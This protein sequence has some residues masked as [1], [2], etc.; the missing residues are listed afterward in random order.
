M[1]FKVWKLSLTG[2]VGCLRDNFMNKEEYKQELI[3]ALDRF[4]GFCSN[5]KERL[6]DIIEKFEDGEVK[7]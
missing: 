7:R 6:K 5:C 2:Q 4:G 3:K 1:R